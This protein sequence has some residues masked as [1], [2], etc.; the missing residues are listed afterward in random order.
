MPVIE[1]AALRAGL[2]IVAPLHSVFVG[3]DRKA[4]SG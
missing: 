4:H 1:L 2:E 3:P